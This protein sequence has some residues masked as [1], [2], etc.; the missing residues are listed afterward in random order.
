[1][2]R[3]YW[4]VCGLLCVGMH[5]SVKAQ[6]KYVEFPGVLG[7]LSHYD[8]NSSTLEILPSDA[9]VFTIFLDKRGQSIRPETKLTYSMN[10]LSSGI[11]KYTTC[12][13]P[14]ECDTLQSVLEPFLFVEARKDTIQYKRQSLFAYMLLF[15]NTRADAE[16]VNF[17]VIYRYDTGVLLAIPYTMLHGKVYEYDAIG[18]VV[19]LFEPFGNTPEQK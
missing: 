14:S 6:E 7:I 9:M 3:V 18:N 8:F 1:M 19:H 13:E 17:I 5:M 16:P 10:L 11:L 12:I 4:F 2:N 15:R